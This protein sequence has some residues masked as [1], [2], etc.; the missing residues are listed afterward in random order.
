MQN[1]SEHKETAPKS[2]H[3]YVTPIAPK[4]GKSMSIY[5]NT[6]VGAYS[7]NTPYDLNQIQE[8][9]PIFSVIQSSKNQNSA[10]DLSVENQSSYYSKKNKKE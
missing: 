9:K 4:H 1:E 3:D 8:S 2:K 5:Q 6:K 10:S 7:M